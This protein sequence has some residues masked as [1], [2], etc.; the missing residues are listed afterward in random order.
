MGQTEAVSKYASSRSTMPLWLGL[1]LVLALPFATGHGQ[2]ATGPVNAM[3]DGAKPKFEVLSVKPTDPAET[4]K[5]LFVQG[6]RVL[7]VNMNLNDLITFAY[8]LNS[9]QL[10][11]TPKWFKDEGF[12]LNGIPDTEGR[13]NTRQLKLLIQAALSDRFKLAFHSVKRTLPVYV[14]TVAKGGPKIAETASSAS[15]LAGFN[16]GGELGDI[17]VTNERCRTSATASRMPSW[18]DPS[19][20]TLDLRDGMTSG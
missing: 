3:A 13:P 11:S 12:D 2:I 1:T 10:T 16:I 6:G 17:K 15:D 14:L 7:V 8:D 4:G 5:K 9:K 20:I 19:S 18:I